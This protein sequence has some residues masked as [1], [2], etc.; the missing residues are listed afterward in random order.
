MAT[1]DMV[2][3][4]FARALWVQLPADDETEAATNGAGER[5]IG[6]S[7]AI[8]GLRCIIQYVALPLILPLIGLTGVFSLPLVIL[9]DLLALA[10]LVRSLRFFWRTRHPRRFD[11]LPLSG[12]I[13][14]VILGSLAYDLWQL[15]A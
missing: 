15:A 5:A 1:I 10:L 6:I 14:L 2:D 11:M 3:R 7:L 9:L 12:A 8:S 4:L 13:L